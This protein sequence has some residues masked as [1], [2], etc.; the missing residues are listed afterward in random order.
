[1]INPPVG[2]PPNQHRNH[3]LL[4]ISKH[5]VNRQT[6]TD[7]GANTG[8]SK[9]ESPLKLRSNAHQFGHED[10]TRFADI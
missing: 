3:S 2:G 7:E 8:S 4:Q 9:D 10:M 1:M 6:I 5:E